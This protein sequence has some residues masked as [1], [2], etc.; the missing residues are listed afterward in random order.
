[1][2]KLINPF[3]ILS[4]TILSACSG[5]KETKV[6]N[7]PI[8]DSSNVIRI[9]Q[10]QFKA[11]GITTGS[12]TQKPIGST[13]K[14]SGLLDVPPQN[15]VSISAPMG[16]FIKST[17]LLQGMKVKKGE[18][19]VTLESTEYIQLQ[20]DYLDSRSKLE[21]L[22]A[23]YNRQEELSR[24]N[25]NARKTVQ[26]AKSQYQSMQAIVKGLKA[27]LSM[28]NISARDLEQGDIHQTV[29]LFS[30]IDGFVTV[31]NVNIGQYVNSTDV[32]FKI[33][34]IE[35]IHAELQLYEKDISSIKVG[36]RVTF[37]FN[38][39]EEERTASVYLIGKEISP[40]RTVRIHCHL[41]KEDE[42]L[43]PGMYITATINIGARNTTVL[44]SKAILSFSGKEYIFLQGPESNTFK[45]VEIKTGNTNDDYTEVV[46]S[47]GVAASSKII[48]EG[49][50]ELLGLLR[51]GEEEE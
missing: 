16:G 18:T 15:M 49:A 44:P 32:M 42:S 48:F 6:E 34:N 39:D 46:S 26:Q 27:K 7:K 41:D 37:K 10:Q 20:Q 45:M 12:L 11:A 33:V 14:L 43:L 23:E 35:H 8:T 40:D 47:E 24:E 25:V 3:F 36:Q 51:N 22:E 4:M 13:L 29:N 28:I 2:Y 50:F 38:Q 19:L 17:K 31:I 9:T 5:G 30:P 21:F 1:M